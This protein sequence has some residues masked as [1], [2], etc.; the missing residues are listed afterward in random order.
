MIVKIVTI[1]TILQLETFS[2]VSDDFQSLSVDK[3]LILRKSF[4][5][6]LAI[7]W[8]GTYTD[9]RYVEQIARSDQIRARPLPTATVAQLLQGTDNI[10]T[11]AKQ[12]PPAAIC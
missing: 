4:F 3:I 6:I 8:H 2:N 10:E 12:S 7:K 1:V 11:N 5:K 9:K